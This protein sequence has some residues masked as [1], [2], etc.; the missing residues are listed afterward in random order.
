MFG[1]YFGDWD[2]TNNFLRAPLCDKTT[3]S[4]V[5]SGRPYWM[6]HHMALGMNIGY[7]AITTQN[8]YSNFGQGGTLG[9][10][11]NTYPTFV[12]IALMGDPSLRLHAIKPPAS[13]TTEI[14]NDTVKIMLTWQSSPDADYYIVLRSGG[15]NSQYKMISGHIDRLQLSFVDA[16]PNHGMNYY[17]VK[18][19]K[20]ELTPSGTYYNTSLAIADSANSINPTGISQVSNK[21]LA[22]NIYPNPSEGL[23]LVAIE[24]NEVEGT[25][26]CFDITGKL[27]STSQTVNGISRVDLQGHS[28]VVIMQIKSGDLVTTKKVVIQ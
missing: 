9:Y 27:I 26:T 22:T 1:S 2:A 11:Y 28:G 23:V 14:L 4:N 17:Q 13:L 3:L 12:H 6:F 10:A 16:N 21:E 5:W 25:I 7:S 8:N 19:V 24:N 18:A 15:Y 20:L